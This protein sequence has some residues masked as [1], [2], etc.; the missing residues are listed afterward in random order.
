MKRDVMGNEICRMRKSLPL[1]S[2]EELYRW[3]NKHESPGVE[4]NLAQFK[5]RREDSV[6][7]DERN[8]N[9]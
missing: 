9:K 1:E 7:S 6:A 8:V 2:R 4:T 3:K 5:Y